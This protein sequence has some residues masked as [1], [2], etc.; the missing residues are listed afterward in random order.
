MRVLLCLVSDQHIPN[1][2]SVHHLQPDHLVLVETA[3]MEKRE[4]STNFLKALRLGGV[5]YSDRHSTIPLDA[6]DR[7]NS[8]RLALQTAYGRF[9]TAQWFVNLT[10]GT[11][12]MSIASYEFFKALDATLLYTNI[13]QPDQ[14]L[15]LETG[16]PETCS[17][18]PSIREFLAG[19][20]FEIVQTNQELAEA[21]CRAQQWAEDAR[22]LAAYA[23][24]DSIL[25][26]DEAL[27]KSLRKGGGDVPADRFRFPTDG[28]KRRWLQDNSSR[29]L[30]KYEADFLTGGWLE[31]FFWNLLR[32]HADALLLWDVTI[33]PQFRRPGDQTQN[34][35]DVAFMHRHALSII[36]CKSGAQEHD[37][38]GDVLYKVEAIKRQFG[39]LRVRSLL[40]TTSPDILHPDGELRNNIRTRAEIYQCTILTSQAIKDLADHADDDSFIKQRLFH[41]A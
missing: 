3:A 17:H 30:T 19:Y 18:K 28:L 16:Q 2:L 9:P 29:R 23:S 11:K 38:G 37:K 10:G 7:L 12:P 34:E 4:V 35:F 40:A 6:E 36:E 31:V 20:G 32:N 33:N 22:E 39:A 41:H 5:D 21:A 25:Q 24:P 1:L 13:S 8:I 26:V 27:R 14:L 15:H